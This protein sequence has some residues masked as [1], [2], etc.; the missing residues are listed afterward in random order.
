MDPL[1][2]AAAQG[3]APLLGPGLDMAQPM[4]GLRE[5]MGQPDHQYPAQ[6]EA[7]PVAMG[8]KVLVQQG[9]E[10]HLSR[11]WPAKTN[12]SRPPRRSSFSVP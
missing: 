1:P 7:D 5:D 12:I 8:R 2:G 10:S 9:L 11:G 6:A 4:I 3:V